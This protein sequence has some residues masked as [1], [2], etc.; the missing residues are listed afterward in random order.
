MK[1]TF[2]DKINPKDHILIVYQASVNDLIIRQLDKESQNVV[3]SAISSNDKS[4]E[5]IELYNYSVKNKIKSLS[6]AKFID[7][8]NTKDSWKLEAF[9]GKLLT[10]LEKINASSVA[11][12]VSEGEKESPK[13]LNILNGIDLKS[14]SFDK[15]KTITKKNYV[16]SIKVI[17]QKKILTPTDRKQIINKQHTKGIFLTRDLVSEPA[18]IL[19][20]SKFVDFCDVLKKVGVNIEVLDEKKMKSLG[21]NALLGVSQGSVKPARIMIMKCMK[22]IR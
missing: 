7:P 6:L 14:Y 10:H 17:D 13:I 19:Y 16:K 4:K 3:K 8:K 1:I 18:N 2:E 5:K 9:G 21:M 22:K 12:I 20:P 15:Y 11:L